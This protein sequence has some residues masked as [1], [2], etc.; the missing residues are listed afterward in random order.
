LKTNIKTNFAER[1]GS[2]D[3]IKGLLIIFMVIYHSLN[4]YGIFP[5][6]E[7]PFVAPGFI[8]MSGFIITQIYFPKY[9]N[10]IKTVRIRLAVRSVK[11]IL[12]FTILNLAAK[13]I[14]PASHLGIFFEVEDF[15][16]NWIDIYLYGSPRTVAFDILLPISYTLLISLFIPKIKP[17]RYYIICISALTMFGTSILTEYYGNPIYTISL[18]SVGIIGIAIGL[19]PLSYI[20]EFTKPWIN[21]LFFF[22]LYGLCFFLFGDHHHTQILSTIIALLIFYSVS[23]RV[24]QESPIHKQLIL[25]GQYSLLSYILQIAYLKAIFVLLSK[26]NFEKPNILITVISI[27]VM[28]YITILVLDYTRQKNKCIDILYKAVFA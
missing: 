25:L 22:V 9:S 28:T 16:G 12:I 15:I 13:I 24:N 19:I 2:I 17:L 10:N 11:L 1:I 27:T 4:Y 6:R 21:V 5:Y 14:W 7:L 3:F 23:E 8:M 20:T 26:G 18:I